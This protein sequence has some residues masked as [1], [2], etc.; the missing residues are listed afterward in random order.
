MTVTFT[1][2][3]EILLEVVSDCRHVKKVLQKG[4]RYSVA[5]NLKMTP[6]FSVVMEY[7][8]E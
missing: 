8:Q 7:S 5:L 1:L 4:V 6:T 2:K 3:G